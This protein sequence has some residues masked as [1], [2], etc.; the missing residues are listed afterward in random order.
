L[1]ANAFFKSVATL[2]DSRICRAYRLTENNYIA[3]DILHG[4]SLYEN[5]YSLES[6]TT[7]EGYLDKA[8]L[9]AAGLD[10]GEVRNLL[11]GIYSNPVDS[12]EAFAE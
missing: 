2:V 3:H 11:L 12:K 5:H 9:E 6:K 7:F 10:A 1:P 4:N 8:V